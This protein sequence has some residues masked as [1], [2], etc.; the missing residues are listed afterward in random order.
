MPKHFLTIAPTPG[1]ARRKVHTA[2]DTIPVDA[3]Q[4]DRSGPFSLLHCG[5]LT[6][7]RRSVHAL[8]RERGDW[9][10]EDPNG[11]L[12]FARLSDR[13]WVVRA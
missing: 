10:R 3:L 1:V 7:D 8:S 6:A 13:G 9:V 5:E 2:S 11:P 4:D 12:S